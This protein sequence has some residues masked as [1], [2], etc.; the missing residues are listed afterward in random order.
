MTEFKLKNL[1]SQ[2]SKESLK[3]AFKELTFDAGE[4]IRQKERNELRGKEKYHTAKVNR[5][6]PQNQTQS[7][8]SS[9][10][11]K[12]ER[13]IRE[14]LTS[15]SV[16]ES[17]QQLYIDII[18]NNKRHLKTV[19]YKKYYDYVKNKYDRTGHAKLYKNKKKWVK[20]NRERVAKFG[21]VRPTETTSSIN[22]ISI[23]MGG[24]NKRY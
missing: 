20:S 8:K 12:D 2:K 7:A 23:P 19:P 9:K 18:K 6:P 4:T 15:E 22:A 11:K 3:N 14:T 1:L 17:L 24:M 5:M 10:I 16:P 13:C 21:N